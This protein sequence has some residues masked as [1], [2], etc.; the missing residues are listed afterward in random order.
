MIAIGSTINQRFT[1]DG[2]L[3]RGGMGAVYRA[4]DLVLGRT[5]AIKVLKELSGEEVKRRIRLEA[6]IL[7]RLAHENVVR[8]YDFGES[9]GLYFLVMEEV[10]GPSFSKRWR[11]LPQ[12]ER[13]RVV[14]EVAEAL[15]YA[16]HQ[17]VI[18][19][20][21]KPAN[22]LLTSSDRAKLSD[23][24]LSMMVEAGDNSGHVR[25]TP[26]Y[27]SPEQAQGKRLDFRTDLYSL[28]VM[29]YECAAGSLPFTGQSL[30][31]IAQHVNAAP[32][33]PRS[34][35]PAVSRE[36]DALI[37]ALLSK[38]PSERPCS[39]QA[40]A[41]ALR[42]EQSRV[43]ASF[44][45]QGPAETAT[46]TMPPRFNDGARTEMPAEGLGTG[47]EVPSGLIDSPTERP[48]PAALTTAA[49]VTAPP[50]PSPPLE[51]ASPLV[52]EMLHDVLAEPAVLSPDERYLTGHYLAFLLGGARRQGFFLRRPNDPRNAD[53]ARLMLAMA[54]LSTVEASEENV[55]RAAKLLQTR[56]EVRPA[57]N[58]LVVVKYLAGRATL[59]KRKRFRAVRKQLLEAC[60]YAQKK[61]VDPRG[62][63][64]PGLMPQSLDDLRRI[65][66]ERDMIDDQLVERWNRVADVWR[67]THDFR[68]AV[69]R[70][71][72][73]SAHRDPLSL[74]LWPEVVYPL[75]ERARW[76]R[77]FRPKHEALFDYLSSAVLHR[78]DAGVRLDRL[79]VR[80]VPAAVVDGLDE[81]IAAFSEEP[82][83]ADDLPAAE[84]PSEVDRLAAS[85]SH[86][87]VQ[88]LVDDQV[89]RDQGLVLLTPVDPYRFTQGEIRELW[90]EAVNALAKPA[91]PGARPAQRTLPVGPYRLAVI[92]SIRGRSAGQVA[93]QG[94]PNKQLEMLTPSPRGGGSSSKPVVAVWIYQDASALVVYLD[95]KSTERFI[96]WHAPTAQQHNFD[97]AADLNHN[98]F[99]LGM[100]VPDQL[101]KAL[102]KR[103]RS[104]GAG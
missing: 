3:G 21:V 13:V 81:E 99:T 12:P 71:A 10:D 14:A 48:G 6:Q 75:I 5:V 29:L 101:G 72:T 40:V 36:L 44:G 84:A 65:A 66:P 63:L 50:P 53:R 70:Y 90:K 67:A 51:A 82:R 7:A 74:C 92:P 79:I 1:L 80:V 89:R 76:Q 59:A 61:M 88:D 23:F 4:T 24:G 22:V 104:S 16:H 95:F 41:Q 30:A 83:L 68:D 2:E 38:D 98:L 17:G 20:D 15:D 58:P 26:H 78:P 35:N 97:L 69:L 46:V 96:L 11:N 45:S 102:S 27:M 56:I 9:E 94:M 57:L 86:M 64:N 31:V 8:L 43:P 42:D 60:P 37:L 47:K 39:G 91:A 52:R 62:L 77:R 100:E 54:W 49:P 25:G 34:K 28:G 55:A 85:V 18:H 87:S 93:L 32:A 73:K 19:R 103:F 33:P